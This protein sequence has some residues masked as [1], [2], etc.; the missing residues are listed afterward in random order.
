MSLT[1][2]ATSL[3]THLLAI[4]GGTALF[5]WLPVEDATETYA[6]LFSIFICTLLTALLLVRTKNL[7][8]LPFHYFILSG[9]LAGTAVAPMTLLLIAFKTGLHAHPVPDYTYQQIISVIRRMPIWMSGGFFI[10][11][12][13]GIWLRSHRTQPESCR[14]FER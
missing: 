4:F 10:S 12:G 7:T 6:I 9:I 5:F 13:L 1:R 11:M 14:A 3:R 8:S 2:S